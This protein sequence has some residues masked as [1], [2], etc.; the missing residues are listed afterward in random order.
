MLKPEKP[1]SDGSNKRIANIIGQIKAT[2]AFI[3]QGIAKEIKLCLVDPISN[4]VKEVYKF[5][6]KSLAS[7]D[8]AEMNAV[9]KQKRL[10]NLVEGLFRQIDTEMAK[11]EVC[12]IFCSI[13]VSICF[14]GK[15]KKLGLVT[16]V[17]FVPGIDPD[18]VKQDFF[19]PT[20]SDIQ[21]TNGIKTK[22]G[23]LSTDYHR[24]KVI[25]ITAIENTTLSN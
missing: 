14:Q 1:K 23:E 4:E 5:S 17:D 24:M 15:P 13:L 25:A 12:F 8:G 22:M 20:D 3:K 6:T 7:N 2:A 21:V 9:V 10:L 18:S 19:K 16:M 11:F